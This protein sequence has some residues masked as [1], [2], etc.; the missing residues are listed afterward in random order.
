MAEANG[1]EYGR[2]AAVLSVLIGTTGLITYG[3]FSL[4]SHTLSEVRVRRHHAAVVGH[5]HHGLGPLPAGRA[6]A[7]ADDRRPRRARARRA[8]STCGSRRRSSSRSASCSRSPRSLCAARSRTTSSTATRTLYWVLIVG[9]LAYAVSYFA[10]GFLAGHHRFGLY[11]GLVMLEAS[12]RFMFALAV[13][14]GIASGQSAVALGM[15]A[16]PIASLIVVPWATRAPAAAG[17]RRA[18]R[19]HEAAD[20]RGARRRGRRRSRAVA[21]RSSRSRN[22]AGF[23]VAVL[24]I[25]LAEQTFLNAGPAAGQ[26]D[27]GRRGRRGAGRVRVQRPADRA[28]AAAALPGDPDLDPPP[29]HAPQ[30]G[31]RGRPVPAQRRA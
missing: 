29:P 7:L 4:A 28:R 16:A 11:G 27:R 6:A 21:S 14:I 10:R 12:S 31:R 1:A 8:P 3:Y 22:G 18:T 26:G 13:A 2:G 25:M 20:V 17:R 24:L 19:T 23:A 15:A 5:V 9:V 30:R